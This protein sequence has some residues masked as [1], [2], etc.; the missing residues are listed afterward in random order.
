MNQGSNARGELVATQSQ[1]MADADGEWPSPR[2]AWTALVLLMF[3]FIVSAIDRGIIALLVEPIKAEY[4]LSDTQFAAL[5]SLA[6]GSF[7][8]IMA[9]PLGV[10]ADRYQRRVVIGA[11]VA[12]FS[13]FS[14]MTGLAR[15]YTQ[16]FI[17]RMGVGFGEAS[18]S[19]AG[20]AMI[21]DYFPPHKLGRAI[22]LFNMCGFIGGALAL[23]GGGFVFGW[24]E[25][26][27]AAD[28]HALLGFAPWQATILLAA[29]PG[30]VLAPMLFM[31]REPVRRGLAGKSKRLPFREMMRELGKRRLFL[32]L[33]IPGMSLANLMTIGIGMWSPALF[34]RVYDWSAPKTGLWLGVMT[35]AG[36]IIGSYLAGWIT[37]RMTM[38][39]RLDAPIRII[40][41]SFAMAGLF[42]TVA[43]LVPSPWMAL[44]FL[45]AMMLFKSMAFASS[46][47]SLQMVIPNQFRAQVNATYNTILSLIGL[48]VGPLVIGLMTD[49]LFPEREGVRYAMSLMTA[50]AAPTM[51]LLLLFAV[52]PFGHLRGA[53]ASGPVD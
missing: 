10:L 41:L 4:G 30:L 40:V 17:A 14:V 37:D 18:V 22:G 52:R 27:D 45:L 20:L 34:I 23:V 26:I 11:G 13:A 39:G 7:Y 21:S 8:A 36:A 9:I 50:L 49:N 44:A 51:A 43:P 42:G 31:L 25:Q 33:L 16:L 47:M 15:N 1:S 5:Q 38:R 46:L 2:L 29:L 53:L 19:P 6:F 12:I 28:P 32:A 24:M 35:L 48:V 3:G